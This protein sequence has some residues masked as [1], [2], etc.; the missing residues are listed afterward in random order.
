MKKTDIILAL[1]AIGTLIVMIIALNVL[2]KN[3]DLM[4]SDP[5][6]I[7]INKTGATC[8]RPLQHYNTALNFP[9]GDLPSKE[10]VP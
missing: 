7:C 4:K 1:V 2:I 3:I 5:C 6:D 10:E 8:F 9:K